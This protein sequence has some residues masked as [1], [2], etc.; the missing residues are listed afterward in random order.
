MRPK[1]PFAASHWIL[2]DNCQNDNCQNAM[3]CNLWNGKKRCGLKNNV[4]SNDD[5]T[6]RYD[7]I[8]FLTIHLK[9]TRYQFPILISLLHSIVPDNWNNRRLW[10]NAEQNVSIIMMKLFFFDL[11]LSG[12]FLLVNYVK[13]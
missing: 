9:G 11:V 2:N 1:S 4:I 6:T 3:G 8:P 5:C 10:S 13:M 7:A 12:I